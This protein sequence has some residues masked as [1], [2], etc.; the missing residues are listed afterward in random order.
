[1]EHDN[2]YNW[3][4]DDFGV[5]YF[6]VRT[7]FPARL[8][9]AMMEL[10]LF[11]HPHSSHSQQNVSI[12]RAFIAE[13]G[14]RWKEVQSQGKRGSALVLLGPKYE[15]LRLYH[16]IDEP[17]DY[18]ALSMG[19]PIPSSTIFIH[20]PYSNGHEVSPF[21]NQHQPT[22]TSSKLPH[23]TAF[24][25][26]KAP[27]A[28]AAPVTPTKMSACLARCHWIAGCKRSKWATSTRTRRS[29]KRG[30][31]NPDLP[32]PMIPIWLLPKKK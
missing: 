26:M 22:S 11:G 9:H 1:M 27:Q 12:F 28:I 10:W 21:F 19:C 18:L 2:I 3:I 31:W 7:W 30:C 20:F 6:Q 5:S 29:L 17:R 16:H 15:S 14:A 8:L 23:M 25:C 4:L 13:L 24:R 32:I